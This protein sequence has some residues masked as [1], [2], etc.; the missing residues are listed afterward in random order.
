MEDEAR[1]CADEAMSLPNRS[2]S[3]R[4]ESKLRSSRRRFVGEGLLR[5]NSRTVGV[6][7]GRANGGVGALVGG[8]P[9][10]GAGAGYLYARKVER[11]GDG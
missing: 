6:V 1:H 3:N 8:A 10:D 11:V 7:G 2:S 5:V 9:G 4:G